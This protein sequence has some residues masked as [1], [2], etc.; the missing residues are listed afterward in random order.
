MRPI[1][2]SPTKVNLDVHIYNVA[3]LHLP[4]MGTNKDF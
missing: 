3:C 1:S 4:A 2:N